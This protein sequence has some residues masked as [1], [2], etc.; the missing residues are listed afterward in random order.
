MTE[1]VSHMALK[2][3]GREGKKHRP[4]CIFKT[5]PRA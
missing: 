2:G 5:I 3:A 4:K 1:C